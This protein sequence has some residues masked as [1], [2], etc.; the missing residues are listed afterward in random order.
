MSHEVITLSN[1]K[2][3]DDEVVKD[4]QKGYATYGQ[5]NAGFA[6]LI[7]LSKGSPTNSAVLNGL[8]RLVYGKGLAARN[9][10]GS[11]A[12]FFA[13][14]LAMI[15][16]MEQK[17]SV[18]DYN[19]M[20]NVALLVTKSADGDTAVIE[21]IP[22]Q[23]VAAGLVDENGDTNA[24]FYSTQLG[25]KETDKI[26]T[27]EY[28][29]FDLFPDSAKSIKYI[30][31]YSPNSWYFDE[32]D[33]QGS[34]EYMEVEIENGKYHVNNVKDRFSAQTGITLFN[35]DPGADKRAETKRAIKKEY[36][37]SEGNT[38]A[39]NFVDK[40]G[41]APKYDH[42]PIR[43][44]HKQQEYIGTEA[45]EKILLGHGV[46]MASIIFGVKGSSGL[47]NNAEE[48][49]KAFITMSNM[50]ILPKQN[51]IIEGYESIFRHYGIPLDFYFK[52]LTPSEFTDNG[53][54]DSI[55]V[56]ADNTTSYNGA[57]IASAVS[58][59]ENV[60]L[61]IL[62]KEQAVIFLIQMLQFDKDVAE[63]MF[64]PT[65]AVA[66]LSK[67]KTELEK[68]IELGADEFEGYD[69]VS[70]SPLDYDTYKT[71]GYSNIHL[72][73]LEQIYNLVSTGTAR[74]NA[75]SKQDSEDVLVR[76]GYAGSKSAERPFCQKMMS[77]KKVYR[78]EDIE[79]L[80]SNKVNPDFQHD[81]KPYSIL[82]LKGGQYCNH[83]WFRKIYVK[84]GVKVDVNSPLAKT[85]SIAEANRKG[86]D[87]AKNP[88]NKMGVKTINLP[89]R[90]EYPN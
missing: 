1:Y 29:N 59:M 35:G 22:T 12:A 34:I 2:R 16:P 89:G 60:K 5:R 33:Y 23:M 21:H 10:D 49:E 52:S 72:T 30:K 85:I 80:D 46:A 19:V 25:N 71:D 7:R 65:N 31:I 62:T 53:A 84:K 51:A 54:S 24:Y 87:V 36:S 40:D 26:V 82:E 77:A 90:G 9:S 68:F 88:N 44:L 48:L 86:Y 47:G 32:P 4:S 63:A 73:K 57:Q 81:G 56:D 39:I 8:N 66:Q 64:N 27:T 45:T 13:K 28:P 42:F 55:D 11:N 50:T 70:D 69:L 79:M 61:G 67:E 74:P 58:V 76:Y 15:S 75:K 18:V 37:G 78:L 20:Y 6:N 38:L 14:A 41:I 17:K 43:D 83:Q 3:K